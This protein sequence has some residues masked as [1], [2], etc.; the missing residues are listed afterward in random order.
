[1]LKRNISLFIAC[2]ILIA[3]AAVFQISAD[4]E[5]NKA[6]IVRWVE[7]WNTG[8]LAIADEVLATDFVSHIPHYPDVTDLESYKGEITKSRT[9][10]PDGHVALEDMVAEGDKVAV[11]L[12]VSGTAQ[13]A[14]VHYTNTCIVICH[15]A[16]GKILEEWWEFD[17]L[18]VMQ[19]LGVIPPTREDYT[20]GTPSE[21]TGDPG[22]PATNKATVQNMFNEIFGNKNLAAIDEV[23]A[24]EFIMHD[25]TSP[26]EIRGPEGY[27]Q[28][29]SMFI[30]GFPDIPVMIDEA[31]A[32]GDKVALRWS[33]SGTQTG[34][35][36]GIPP[37][38]RR[39]TAAGISIFR[40]AD[41]KI[42]EIWV[43]YDALGIM[44]QLTMSQ[45]EAN[46]AISRR[47]FEE[48]LNQGK[49]EVYDEIV[50]PEV[51]LHKSSGDF[52]G[53]EGFKAVASMYLIAFPDFHITIDDMV[54]E[55]DMVCVRFT[56][57]GTHQGELMG[58]PAT[59]A[60]VVGTGMAIHRISDGR[61]QEAW[62]FADELGMMQQ[63]GVMP[64]TR[65]D[66]TWGVPSEVTG[67]PGDPATNKA[68]V[69]NMFNEIF[70]S[71]NLAVIDENFAADFIMHDPVTPM[72]IRGPEGYKQVNGVYFTAF[73]DI[74]I[75]I[76]DMIA[77]GDR[78]AV[79]Y[80]ITGTHTGEFMGIPATG[81]RITVAGISIYR[82]ADGKIV[83][84]WASYD[85]LGMMQQLTISQ[86]EA[87]KAVVQRVADEIWNKGNLAVVGEIFAADF[88]NHDPNRLDTLDLDS[89]KGWV[90]E[91]LTAYPDFH[92]E[93]HDM[94]AQGDKV[95]ARL[96]VTGTHQGELMG[97]PPTCKQVTMTAMNIHRL[98]GGKVVEVWWSYDTLGMTQQLG[99]IPP[100]PDAPMPFLN[101]SGG[102]ENFVWG[103][104]SAVTGDP[105]DPQANR[106]LVIRSVEEIWNIDSSDL[107]QETMDEIFSAE[108][109][110][111]DPLY[112]PIVMDAESFKQWIF[113]HRG[114]AGPAGIVI[115]DM[116]IE[117]DKIA[118]RSIVKPINLSGMTIC[119][120]ADGKM[121]EQWWSKD[122]L[123]A[124]I[125]MGMLPPLPEP[126]PEGYDSVFFMYLSPGLN[127]ISLPLKP[128]EP[129]TARSFA[130][131]IGATVVIR[132]D[133]ALGKF[134]GFTATA[135]G[136]GF[137]IEGGEGYIV[138]VL[139]GGTVAFTGAAW[140]NEPPVEAAPPAQ[141]STAWAFVVSGSVLDGDGMSAADGS[142]TAIVKNL[143]TGDT[144]TESVDSSGYFA[145]AWA[146]LSRKA[147]IGS[148]DQVEVAVVDSSG[149]IVSGPFIHDI[150]L[151]E[152]RNAVANLHLKLGKII[153]EKTELLQNY[154]N[155]FNPET[156]IP[157]HLS[158]ANSVIIK[159]YGAS[160]Q[161][162]RTLDLG[163]RYA[164]IYA[165]RSKAAY[166]D[167]RNEAGEV[168]AGG[169]YFYSITAGDFSA[170]RKMIV[171]K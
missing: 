2:I 107:S 71:K 79:P 70:G 15:F 75:T 146:D 69:Q 74:Q 132:Y 116:I 62:L 63:L 97:I 142:Y 133:T 81:R 39:I 91:T 101:R 106:E 165:S 87:N 47:D 82:F 134:V 4:T 60:S 121:V 166:W 99:V 160:G 104:P 59:G 105:G 140:T 136:D 147:V 35:F 26:M 141:V 103:E 38:G 58:M 130:E 12:T 90:V 14:G 161:L 50:A 54:A 111:H 151:D 148:G 135:S 6:V 171:K 65:E 45:E 129:Y 162:V 80:T 61:I 77:E 156:W 20:W 13:P 167:G 157:Y 95:A 110:N 49:L 128:I 41:S 94:V 163:Y 7:L 8:D 155:P 78:V 25:P 115:E 37:T 67:D 144:F 44:Q 122:V 46:K 3:F 68:A 23:V 55:G 18:G 169:V 53:L 102:S 152:I 21:V 51:V 89:Y 93:V 28:Y 88:V 83:E 112:S 29:N 42:V 123:P 40:F 32:E 124:L 22:D 11:R 57:T 100:M 31:F 84:I 126:P 76:R 92:V 34:E 48:A 109:I 52:T 10:V 43:S 159:I 73:P 127:M 139:E 164:G 5:A 27:K 158:D 170:T 131:E 98:D 125:A 143:R 86:E 36:M 16:D 17:L 96:T 19:Q 9:D 137:A 120:F 113:F 85:A 117:G 153:P 149:E 24:D 118:Y 72:E 150:K 56:N 108:F 154:P 64:P 168:V 30:T 138:N 119:R 66:Y 114:D 33:A 145:A 1:M